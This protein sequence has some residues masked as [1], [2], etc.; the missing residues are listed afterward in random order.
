VAGETS[1]KDPNL[2]RWQE[3]V[4]RKRET[5]STATARHGQKRDPVRPFDEGRKSYEA[6]FMEAPWRFSF[7]AQIM[8]IDWIIHRTSNGSFSLWQAGEQRALHAAN[9]TE[10]R[11]QLAANSIVD[12]WAQSVFDQLEK[13]DT[14]HVEMPR[15][16][17]FSKHHP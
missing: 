4:A 5:T 10:P 15:Q 9:E 16:A 13:G 11:R 12:E 1:C 14:A 17:Q 6:S 3:S 8:K 2:E 7:W